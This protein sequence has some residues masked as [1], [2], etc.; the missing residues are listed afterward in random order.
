MI[1][2]AIRGIMEADAKPMTALEI[3]HQIM[4]KG[5]YDFKAKDP[6]HVVGSQLRKHCLGMDAK[7]YPR[8]KFFETV[9]GNRFRLLSNPI[10]QSR[11][12]PL[13]EG[14]AHPSSRKLAESNDQVGD[15][16][17]QDTV[18][19]KRTI[20]LAIKEVMLSHGKPMTAQEVYD[21]I[22][23]RNLYSFKASQP[24]HVVR[25][26][27]RRHCLGLDFP[28]AADVKHFGIRGKDRYYPLPEAVRQKSKLNLAA[29]VKSIVRLPH[30]K[31]SVAR[32]QIFISYSHKDS[33][34]LQRLQIHLRPLEKLGVIDRWD[35]TR[36]RVGARWR[37]EIKKAIERA[38]V[39][40]LLISAD[41]LASE[42]IVDNELPPLL[43]AAAYEGVMI[44]PVIISPCR[45]EKTDTI[46]QFQ[47]INQPSR[48]LSALDTNKR[49]EIFVKVADAVESALST[50]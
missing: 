39:A 44:L 42:F 30:R 50:L 43:Q 41:F 46:S 31:S 21:A 49:E 6:I 47:A 3:Y 28:T 18:L 40:V 15:E 16:G 11:A 26:Q 25:S 37:N 22:T 1:A 32:N 5:L 4:E 38:R 14:G 19:A 13:E 45:F 36:I 17:A 12:T 2:D 7:S 48:P 8:L 20:I 10:Y 9:G 23:A 34:W 27:I 24:V 33:K 29:N 35:D